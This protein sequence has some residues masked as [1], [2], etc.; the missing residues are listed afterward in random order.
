ME[1][2]VKKLFNIP[3]K[4][5]EKAIERISWCKICNKKNYLSAAIKCQHCNHL[6]H[7]KCSKTVKQNNSA[8]QECLAE[9]FPFARTDLDELLEISFSS[10]F[11]CKCLKNH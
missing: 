7:K 4:K 6:N 2:K 8:C 1:K 3:T 5:L 11:D 10:N 9:A